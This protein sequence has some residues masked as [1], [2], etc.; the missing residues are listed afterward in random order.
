MIEGCDCRTIRQ[1]LD[2]AFWGKT[3]MAE[4]SRILRGVVPPDVV[5]NDCA[6]FHFRDTDNMNAV[7]EHE[8]FLALYGVAAADGGLGGVGRFRWNDLLATKRPLVSHNVE[9]LQ[10]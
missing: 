4:A 5:L 6:L 2:P 8:A 9:A 1:E 7:H 3:E 10:Y